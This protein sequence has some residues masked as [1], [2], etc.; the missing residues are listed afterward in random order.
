M[1]QCP[2]DQERAF[3]RQRE[4]ARDTTNPIGS[5]ELPYLSCH[6]FE[7]SLMPAV[8]GRFLH[9]NRNP[10]RLRSQHL[11]QRIG[12]VGVGDET[13]SR[14]RATYVDGVGDGGLY[15]IDVLLRSA[16]Q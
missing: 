6:E 1:A 2:A 16:D 7:M 14:N 11:Y 9:V 5:A 12:H 15:R 8:C 3:Q 13:P 10:H 4:F